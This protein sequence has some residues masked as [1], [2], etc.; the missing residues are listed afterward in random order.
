MT[1]LRQTLKRKKKENKKKKRFCQNSQ[2]KLAL[3][4]LTG[5]VVNFVRLLVSS[6]VRNEWFGSKSSLTRTAALRKERTSTNYERR[7][8]RLSELTSLTSVAFLNYLKETRTKP[9]PNRFRK[10]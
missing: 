8:G 10:K 2:N 3:F 7:I 5:A 1:I 9:T 4:Y 6:G